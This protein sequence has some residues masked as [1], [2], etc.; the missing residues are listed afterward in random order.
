[1]ISEYH[2]P[3]S[4][5]TAL[6]LLARKQPATVPL[7]GG[8][9][10]S[11]KS[12]Q[13][14]AVVDIQDLFLNSITAEG[15]TLFIGAAVTLQQLV[16]SP[17]VPETLREMAQKE[18]SFNLRQ[19]AS[20]GGTIA[21]GGSKSILLAGLLALDAEIHF[22][23]SIQPSSLGELLPMRSETLQGKLITSVT[24]STRN[25]LAYERLSKTPA[26]DSQLFVTIGKWP[27][28]RTRVVVG[29]MSKIPKLVMDGPSA[30]GA[31]IAAAN[32]C[33]SSDGYSQEVIRVLAK[34]C[35]ERL[36]G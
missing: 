35:V 27:N 21:A 29:G 33:E 32:C 23:G 24:V 12:Q 31:D 17:L 9:V 11:Q 15:D 34:R 8:T 13:E 2:R 10:L 4:I 20:V 18:T 6:E 22:A 30:V 1:M 36:V 16:D 7:A 5:Q 14:F 28:G 25:N 19:M 3:S 26:D